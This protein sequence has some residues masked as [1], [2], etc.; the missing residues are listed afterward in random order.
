MER[1]PSE[2]RR[3]STVRPLINGYELGTASRRNSIMNRRGSAI[4][5]DRQQRESDVKLS[6]AL[7][8]LAEAEK[9]LAKLSVDYDEL[10]NKSK[11][12]RKVRLTTIAT[13]STCSTA[14]ES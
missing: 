1:R 5:L 3:G 8:Q 11:E 14:A 10:L 7:E 9:R 12:L 4:D 2:K 6:A 13:S